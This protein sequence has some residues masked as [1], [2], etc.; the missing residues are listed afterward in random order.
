MTQDS[1]V[2]VTAEMVEAS[3]HAWY[4][5]GG[6]WKVAIRNPEDNDRYVAAMRA[7]MQAAIAAALAVSAVPRLVE[8]ADRILND[9]DHSDADLRA[10]LRAALAALKEAK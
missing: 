7:D 3:L 4:A 6:E 10:D 8:A 5:D 1:P 2:P 9:C